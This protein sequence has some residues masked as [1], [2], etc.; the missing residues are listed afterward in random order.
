MDRVYMTFVQA[1]T[2]SGGWPMSV[3]LT[4]DRQPFYGGTYFPPDVAVGP[5]GFPRPA[6]RGGP[7][8]ARGPR[9]RSSRPR[10]AFTEELARATVAQ[11]GSRIAPADRALGRAVRRAAGG[12]FDH[13]HGGF[14]RAPKFPRPSELLFLLR[15]HAPD[16]AT[17]GRW[18]W[19]RPRL[20][21][22]ATAACATRWAAASTATRW[23]SSGGCR[24]SRRCCTT[25]RRSSSPCLEASQAAGDRGLLGVAED[26]LAYVRRDLTDPS[27]G[28]YSA[29]DAD[30]LPHDAPEGAHPTEGAY[31]LWQAGDLDRLLGAD[32]E[33]VKTCF[34]VRPDGNALHDP[35]GE[36]VGR[37]I[38]YRAVGDEEAASQ[39]GLDA[40]GVAAI[41]ARARRVL[42][43]ARSTRPRPGLDD[44]VLTAWNGLMIAAFARASRVVAA[45]DPQAA[46]RAGEYL[47]VAA[48]AAAFVR[49][50]LWDEGRGRLLRRYRAGEAGVDGYAEDHACLVF[51]LIE[52]FQASGDPDH[53]RFAPPA[54]A[55][56][57]ELFWDDGAGGWF[58][59]TGQ[60]ASVPLRLKEEHD[61]AEPAASSV[62]ALNLIALHSL[63]SAGPD[64]S[65]AGLRAGDFLS[66][67][68]RTLQAFEPRLSHAS[69][70]VPMMLAA[71]SA[72]HAPRQEIVVAGDPADPRTGALVAA[73]ESRYRPFAI[74]IRLA[75]GRADELARELPHVSGMG[76]RGGSPAAYVCRNF[77]CDAPVTD[78]EAL[79]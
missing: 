42:F 1:T 25:R 30:S 74:V 17:R 33:V 76:M 77:A 70:A 8:L 50:R 34:G 47:A 28:F 79:S 57:D 55:R 5:A 11:A 60:D 45:L 59:T 46:P 2:G 6:A 16:R 39:H 56:Q 27:G 78:P 48:R 15:E 73:V 65:G 22:M 10:R 64:E 49:E 40:A 12:A 54:A 7:A 32:A 52:L 31:Y 69:R 38:L 68:E 3:W 29:E 41:V 71:L 44:K 23:T 4:P 43:E 72:Y 61:G 62:G 63:S 13:R 14:G 66:R 35:Q 9:T 58:S 24:T 53:L 51:G 18:R 36:F 67:A 75:P 26:T 21:A 19:C 20:R 37:N